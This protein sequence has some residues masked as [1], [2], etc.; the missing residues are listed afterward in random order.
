MKKTPILIILVLF[1]LLRP[2]AAAEVLI[3]IANVDGN[4]LENYRGI[5]LNIFSI[6]ETF[7]KRLGRALDSGIVAENSGLKGSKIGRAHV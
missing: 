3:K 6:N 5:G 7:S 4:I 1:T 2:L